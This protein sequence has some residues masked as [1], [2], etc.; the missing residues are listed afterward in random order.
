MQTQFWGLQGL[1]ASGQIEAGSVR[2]SQPCSSRGVPSRS[3]GGPGFWG[4]G[5]FAF[6][7]HIVQGPEKGG[8]LESAF[9]GPQPPR[10]LPPDPPKKTRMLSMVRDLGS[11]LYRAYALGLSVASHCRLVYQETLPSLTV[12][13]RRSVG[14]LGRSLERPCKWTA[15]LS[16]V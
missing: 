4:P 9:S 10:S 11:S 13:W 14:D 12:P 2:W 15:A 1:L 16:A 3:R 7:G 8:S 5:S 6:F